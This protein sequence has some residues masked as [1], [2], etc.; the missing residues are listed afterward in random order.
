MKKYKE[1][2]L[3]KAKKFYGTI[4]MIFLIIVLMLMIIKNLSEI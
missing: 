1:E 4:S 2:D 3:E